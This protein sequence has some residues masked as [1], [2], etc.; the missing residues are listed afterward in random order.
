MKK[1]IGI[2]PEW[3]TI[4]ANVEKERKL[5]V[6]LTD[7][8]FKVDRGGFV[9][10]TGKWWHIKH[11]TLILNLGFIVK[12]YK[13]VHVAQ[14]FSFVRFVDDPEDFNDFVGKIKAFV[15][16]KLNYNLKQLDVCTYRPQSILDC[17]TEK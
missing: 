17:V 5:E 4:A 9:V 15:R 16:E 12:D 7:M 1:Q 14:N 6:D 8:G 10:D 11:K 2:P 13:I 3:I